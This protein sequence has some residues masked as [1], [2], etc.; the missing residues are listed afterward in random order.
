[1]S[2]LRYDIRTG[3]KKIKTKTALAISGATLGFAGVAMA[4]AVPLGAHA[5]VSQNYSTFDNAS[6]VSGGNPGNAVQMVSDTSHVDGG[7]DYTDQSGF[8]FSSLTNLG[9]DY[10]I[11]A[12]DCGGGSP[13]FQI[14]I[15]SHNVF[16]YLGPSPN[17]TGCATNSWTPTGNLTT[18]ADPIFDTSQYVGGA[19][20]STYAQAETLLGSQTVT[21][22]QLVTDGGWAVSGNNQTVLADNTQI[23]TT[24][25]DYEPAPT[26]KV[27]IDKFVDGAQATAANTNSAS[28]PMVSSWNAT[29][30][31]ASSGSYSLG[32]VGFNNS[33]PYFATT[34]DMSLG[35]DYAT[36]EVT[37][38]NNVVSASCDGS[39]TYALVG[40]SIGN[41][42]AD[43][44]AAQTT[45]TSPSF[46]NL[47]SDQFVIVR[48]RTCPPVLS[49]PTN[50]DQCKN[51]GW[52]TLADVNNRAFKNQGDCV[53]YV[54]TGGKNKAN[55]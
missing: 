50:K 19:Q 37:T 16:V 11:T 47:Q 55:G 13:R 43:A 33:T 1:M 17:F 4:I 18:S 25:Y 46:T 2:M 36:N 45:T 6:V 49:H 14:N 29:N 12:G 34:S 51:N 31:G 35:A 42:L 41:T 20:Y 32:P 9:T 26:V 21:G 22:I 23:N 54:A 27:T 15:G 10:K 48:N 40:Y 5:A 38:G 24:T 52:Q 53:S 3:V 44:I 30:I 8:L 39:A 28:F 7:I